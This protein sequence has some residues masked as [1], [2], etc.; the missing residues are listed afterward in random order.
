MRK[1][2]LAFLSILLLGSMVALPVQAAE[3]VEPDSKD[4]TISEEV[5][6][7]L[8]VGAEE[9][10]DVEGKVNGDLVGGGSSVTVSEAVEGNA[11]LAGGMINVNN[12]IG[13]N[14]IAAG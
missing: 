2:I 12:F 5:N 3:V 8:Y 11:L 4:V 7:D 6:D 13:N 10:L 9:D 1:R 14:L